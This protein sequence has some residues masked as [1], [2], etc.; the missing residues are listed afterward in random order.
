[1]CKFWAFEGGELKNLIIGDGG[2]A[3]EVS[4]LIDFTLGKASSRLSQ[5]EE[6]LHLQNGDVS[7]SNMFIGIGNPEIR[8]EVLERWSGHIDCFPKLQHPNTFI[9]KSSSVSN[10]CLLQFGVVLSSFALLGR[11]VLLNWNVTV[12]HHTEIG[13]GTVVNP[14]AAISGHCKIGSGVLIGT[15]ARILEG[16]TIG[17]SAIIGAGAVVTKNVPAGKCYVGIPAREMNLQN[18]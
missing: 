6:M 13:S 12:G 17:S 14:G 4:E 15:G 9:S 10:G 5:N 8:L 16:V 1:V 2:H 11:G 18:E 7:E 3:F